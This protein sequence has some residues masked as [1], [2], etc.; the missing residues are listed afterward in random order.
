MSTCYLVALSP[1]PTDTPEHCGVA[2]CVQLQSMCCE[3][4]IPFVAV[5]PEQSSTACPP[6]H[7]PYGTT[8][9]V[10]GAADF[11]CIRPNG[12]KRSHVGLS[13]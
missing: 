11:G 8:K 7:A 5:P 9:K 10:L 6:L 4:C 2:G 12:P 13:K 3:D 1:D